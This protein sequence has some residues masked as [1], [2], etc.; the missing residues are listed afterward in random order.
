MVRTI[1]ERWPRTIRGL[2]TLI[3]HSYKISGDLAVIE[4]TL[5]YDGNR[6]HA[7]EIV[8]FENGKVK[9]NRSYF[10]DPFEAPEWRAQWVERI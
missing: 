8:E 2:A 4:M 6:T 7:C 5:D 10:G 1:G 9:W 3:N